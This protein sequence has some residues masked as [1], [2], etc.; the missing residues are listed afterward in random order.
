M[1]CGAEISASVDIYIYVCVTLRN[2]ISGGPGGKH[3]FKMASPPVTRV[4]TLNF[5]RTKD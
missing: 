3:V 5:W 2:V 4:A 1:Q